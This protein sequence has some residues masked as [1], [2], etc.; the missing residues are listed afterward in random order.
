MGL[1]KLKATEV[2]EM[3]Y[4]N[5]CRKMGGGIGLFCKKC[6]IKLI[7]E[8]LLG[9][10]GTFRG[11]CRYLVAAPVGFSLLCSSVAMFHLLGFGRRYC[12]FFG[13]LGGY[14]L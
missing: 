5:T 4:C 9:L 2:G 7:Q 13:A 3:G 10:E 12:H 1:G 11:R 6:K 8:F 14:L